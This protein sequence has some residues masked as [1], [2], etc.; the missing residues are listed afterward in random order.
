MW[1]PVLPRPQRRDPQSTR[2]AWIKDGLTLIPVPPVSAEP[3]AY[4][5]RGREGAPFQR[6]SLSPVTEDWRSWA[7]QLLKAVDHHRPH[8]LG[9]LDRQAILSM[10]VGPNP[11]AEFSIGRMEVD[12]CSLAARFSRGFPGSHFGTVGPITL[13]HQKRSKP[14]PT[15]TEI[16]ED[17]ESRINQLIL[18]P[19]RMYMRKRRRHVAHIWHGEHGARRFTDHDLH[20]SALRDHITIPALTCILRL[21]RRLEEGTDTQKRVHGRK[22]RQSVDRQK[23]L[24]ARRESP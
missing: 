14:V 3:L 22:R 2:P 8:R 11:G 10:E 24:V 20:I 6:S 4:T 23:L 5:A 12:V 21:T 18:N 17:G 7:D 19:V 1:A 15:P 16:D 9:F 13:I